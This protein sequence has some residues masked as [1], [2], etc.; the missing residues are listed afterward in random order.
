MWLKINIDFAILNKKTDRDV[1]FEC[2]WVVVPFCWEVRP[3]RS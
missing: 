1:L 2:H 3:V